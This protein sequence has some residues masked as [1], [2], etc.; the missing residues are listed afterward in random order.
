MEYPAFL[1]AY[2]G[3]IGAA[4]ARLKPD[5][6]A[7]FVVGD[8]RAPDGSYRGF[9]ADTCAAFAAAGLALYNEAVL[10]TALGSVPIRAGR[11]FESARKLGKTHQNVLVFVKGDARRAT[12]AVGPVQFGELADQF[13]EALAAPSPPPAAD[14]PAGE[15]E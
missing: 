4:C 10:I 11:Q 15:A 12:A 2:R 3:I 13:G 14:A 7:C 6:F 1:A 8:V 5:R 9:V